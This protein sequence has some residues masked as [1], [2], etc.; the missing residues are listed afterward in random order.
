MNRIWKRTLQRLACI[1]KLGISRKFGSQN[2]DPNISK[3][4]RAILDSL[5]EMNIQPMKNSFY[6]VAVP[7]PPLRESTSSLGLGPLWGGR[8][9]MIM[10]KSGTLARISHLLQ[11]W[12]MSYQ[13]EEPRGRFHGE[14][15]A[16]ASVALISPRRLS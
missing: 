4:A 3:S 16:W 5:Q 7:T 9:S 10:D 11:M 2:V 8:L 13:R 14:C 1:S 12:Q 6:M 15:I